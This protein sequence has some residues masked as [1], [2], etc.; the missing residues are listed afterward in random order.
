LET[1][2]VTIMNIPHEHRSLKRIPLFHRTRE[3]TGLGHIKKLKPAK[4]HHAPRFAAD[5]G[6]RTAAKRASGQRKAADANR[7]WFSIRNVKPHAGK[8]NGSAGRLANASFASPHPAVISTT[9][10]IILRPVI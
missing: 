6:R 4:L 5:R 8:R 9:I 7:R 2:D 10:P 3:I 1:S